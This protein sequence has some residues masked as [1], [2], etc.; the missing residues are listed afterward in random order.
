M[1]YLRSQFF[2]R[3]DAQGNLFHR[4]IVEPEPRGP[5][6]VDTMAVTSGAAWGA[7]DPYRRE[8]LIR[9][10]EERRDYDRSQGY[11]LTTMG[12]YAGCIN[13]GV[14]GTKSNRT[15]DS[16]IDLANTRDKAVFLENWGKWIE[17][18]WLSELSWDAGVKVDYPP[19]VPEERDRW[20]LVKNLLKDQKEQF[21]LHGVTEAIR[22]TDNTGTWPNKY[23]WA[24]WDD[25]PMWCISRYI[26]DRDPLGE[27]TWEPGQEVWIMNSPHRRQDGTPGLLPPSAARDYAERGWGVG[28]WNPQGDNMVN[29]PPIGTP[30]GIDGS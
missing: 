16:V 14:A 23:T 5:N 13:N 21:G 11:D 19:R 3:R 26:L 9:I 20:P 4:Y 10:L 22:W 6:M 2:D 8:C 17:G 1:G 27:L 18:G 15:A 30:G 25:V 7:Y 12:F 24:P 29:L 28:T